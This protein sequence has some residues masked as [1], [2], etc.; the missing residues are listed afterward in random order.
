MWWGV[1][2]VAG[3]GESILRWIVVCSELGSSGESKW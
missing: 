3:S 1:Y 2:N